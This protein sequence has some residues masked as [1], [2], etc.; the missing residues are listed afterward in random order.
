MKVKSIHLF[1][2][3]NYFKFKILGIHFG[4]RLRVFNKVYVKKG[5]NSTIIIGD[6]LTFISGGGYN[7]IIVNSRGCICVDNN[8]SLIIGNNCGF[9]STVLWVKEGVTIGDN[10]M[11]GGGSIILD[12]DCHSL[13]YRVRN[14]CIRGSK[15]ERVDY[16]EAKALPVTIEDDVLVGARCIILK[17]VTIGA[18]SIIGA[19]S[20]VSK[21]IPSDCIAA[22]NPCR[23]IKR[24]EK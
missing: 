21:S 16:R 8:A 15:G 22:G 19:G 24:I 9:S 6:K 17:G 2:L 13:D 23:V 3:L 10:V 5:S 14:G 7:P 11:I 20:V 1:V 12:N 4:K 18:R